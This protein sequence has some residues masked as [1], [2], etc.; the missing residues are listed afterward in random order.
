MPYSL[1][2]NVSS[3]WFF[4]INDA[5]VAFESDKHKFFLLV[6]LIVFFILKVFELS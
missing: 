6:N 1:N 5:V 3:Y 2:P 4:V